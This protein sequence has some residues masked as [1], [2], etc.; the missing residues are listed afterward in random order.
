LASDHY[1]VRDT[2]P[3][4]AGRLVHYPSPKKAPSLLAAA[5]L[6]MISDRDRLKAMG[7]AA[8]EA[9]EARA[10]GEAEGAGRATPI[11]RELAEV[12]ERLSY[13][14]AEVER[15][16]RAQ[17]AGDP[18]ALVPE[19]R[20]HGPW[21]AVAAAANSVTRHHVTALRDVLDL[22][23]AWARGDFAP[24]LRPGAGRPA[25]AQATV[26]RVRENLRGVAQELRAL[27]GAAVEGRLDVRADTT[28]FPGEWQAL[29]RG[30]NETLDAVLMPLLMSAESFERI[31]RGDIPDKLTEGL[32]GEY[33]TIH[34]N[35]NRC[36]DAVR[37]LVT[38]VD[39]LATAA[40]AG[41]LGVRADP[42]RHAGEFRRIVEG[43]N[44]TLDAVLAPIDESTR[45]LERLARR[46]LTV[47]VNGVYRGE[48]ARIQEA[49]NS[50]AQALHDAMG[51]VATV[52][53]QVSSAAVQIASSSQS[54]ASGA[55]EQA[56]SLA[57][58]ATTVELIASML[59]RTS[60]QARQADATVRGARDAAAEGSQSMER[61][62]AAMG[63][64][65]TSTEGTSQIIKDINEIAFQTNL[66]ALNAAVEAAR[67][68]E[69]GR[70][71]AVVAEEVRSLALRSKEAAARTEAL[72]RESLRQAGEGEGT[73]RHV[74]ER[75]GAIVTSVEKTTAIVAEISASAREQAEG[76]S[77]VMRA[78]SEMDKVTQQN[79]ASAEESSSA[80]TE[81]S[82][83]AHE[84]ADLVAAFTLGEPP[85]PRRA[86][87]PTATSVG[88]GEGDLADF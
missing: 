14:Q 36:V 48:H 25:R 38:D 37:G 24:E 8:R 78:V 63:A 68:G 26:D 19:E 20:F 85:A 1:G 10:A 53:E 84:L 82:G 27:T 22:L 16:S 81:L 43:V 70:G 64:I 12:R 5:L 31:S 13:L 50:S 67:A 83:Q 18:D 6:E 46:D 86:A 80:A 2:L 51:Q 61:M 72:I 69:A 66:L 79:A 21:R 52:V 9:A 32:R 41:R 71:F 54:V 74:A 30:V 55:S 58:Y 47:R 49:I 87:R 33:D 62:L 44:R 28:R 73:S 65:R 56:S 75:L 11:Q 23:D 88:P 17:L 42:A 15:A 34:Q 29:V 57:E 7:A 59:R 40:I 45:A 3:P 76:I 4:E 39:A 60:D 35:V 77:G